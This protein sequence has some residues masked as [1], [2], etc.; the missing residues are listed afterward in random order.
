[1]STDPFS[2]KNLTVLTPNQ[3]VLEKFLATHRRTLPAS[4]VW[5]RAAVMYAG[6]DQS[7]PWY[8]R[9]P[10]SPEVPSVHG[11]ALKSLSPAIVYGSF[12]LRVVTNREIVRQEQNK[13]AFLKI[14][15]IVPITLVLAHSDGAFQVGLRIPSFSEINSSSAEQ[16][17]NGFFAVDLNQMEGIPRLPQICL[18]T[19]SQVMPLPGLFK[20]SCT[21]YP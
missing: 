10:E 21:S 2:S 12:R 15:A 1:M 20:W 8:R 13:F 16:T 19:R 6:P 7:L 17:A 9:L 14:N 3:P 4:P 18:P 11:I 5:P